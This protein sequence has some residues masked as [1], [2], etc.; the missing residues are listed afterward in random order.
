MTSWSWGRV[1]GF[2][3]DGTKALEIKSVMIGEWVKYCS[4]CVTSFMNDPQLKDFLI[5]MSN[6]VFRNSFSTKNGMQITKLHK[7]YKKGMKMFV[8][9]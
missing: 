2:C 3:D 4:N 6:T 5:R 7:S 9:T 8:I 1:K